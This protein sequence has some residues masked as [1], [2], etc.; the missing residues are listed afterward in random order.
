MGNISVDQA[1]FDKISKIEQKR[2]DRGSLRKEVLIKISWCGTKAAN[3]L[4]AGFS[5]QMQKLL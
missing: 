4:Y 3:D 2:W 1:N 5:V